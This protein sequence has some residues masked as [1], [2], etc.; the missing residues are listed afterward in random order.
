MQTVCKFQRF[1]DPISVQILN[2]YYKLEI[3]VQI[4]VNENLYYYNM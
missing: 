3:P 1:L 2:P 4:R